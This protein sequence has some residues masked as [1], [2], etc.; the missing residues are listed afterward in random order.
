V[1][2]G[3]VR[4]RGD[5]GWWARVENAPRPVAGAGLVALAALALGLN[6]LDGATLS[7]GGVY[8][9]I[10]SC[11]AWLLGFRTTML[12]GLA[13]VLAS[14]HINRAVMGVDAADRLL[15]LGLRT[16]SLLGGV[17]LITGVRRRYDRARAFA[18]HDPLTGVANHR[19][20]GEAVAAATARAVRRGSVVL[21]AYLDLDDFKALNDRRGH[22]AG[23]AVL[24]EVAAAA[25]RA[26]RA[27][28]RVGRLG[29]D[30]FALLVEATN[31]AE[32]E[33]AIA[34]IH[35]ALGRA[36]PAAFSMGAVI[37]RPADA[38]TDLIAEADRLMYRSKRT[39]KGGLTVA[40]LD[41]AGVTRLAA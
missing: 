33:T 25:G 34:R 37:A 13:V 6:A 9:L 1:S 2:F 10:L 30:E 36:M 40:R 23:D 8:A 20:F 4:A 35:A 5:E 21:L 28:D 14:A 19:A 24:R 3:G 22:A 11:A 16:G 7:F 29:G 38:A 18:D 31:E 15:T 41:D 26:V 12:F 17:A 32:A 39:A 27:G